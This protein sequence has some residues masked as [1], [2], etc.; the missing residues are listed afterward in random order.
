MIIQIPAEIPPDTVKRIL[1]EAKDATTME[2]Q[3]RPR[4]ADKRKYPAPL[5]EPVVYYGRS[6]SQYPETIRMSFADGHTEIYDRR[7]NQ[8]R[9]TAYLNDPNRRRRKP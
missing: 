6:S 7:V 4:R 1:D 2:Q 8:P 5:P 9:P 3:K